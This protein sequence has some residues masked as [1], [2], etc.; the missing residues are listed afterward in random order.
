MWFSRMRVLPALALVFGAAAGPIECPPAL[1]QNAGHKLAN[2]SL[3]DGPPA[4]MADL[5]P[6]RAG[7]IDRWDLDGVDPYLV[8]RFARTDKIV[9]LHAT[10]AGTCRAGGKPFRA[11]C[12]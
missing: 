5:V 3:F 7:D 1:P 11:G 8:C 4:Q 12:K 2:A 10:G 6:N 9:V